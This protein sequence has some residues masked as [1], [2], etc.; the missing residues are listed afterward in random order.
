MRQI[1]AN[2]HTKED[3]PKEEFYILQDNLY[4]QVHKKYEDMC[5]EV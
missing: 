3:G 5:Q 4:A 2:N 1:S